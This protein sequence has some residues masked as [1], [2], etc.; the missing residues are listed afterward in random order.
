VRGHA[1][2]IEARAGARPAG[3]R[4]AQRPARILVVAPSW[5][6]DT[7]LAQPLLMR[8]HA[9]HPG[10][11]ID[12]LAPPWTGPLLA[13]MPEV[14]SVIEN[15]FRHG[16][17]KV[18]ARRRLG[19][20]LRQRGYQRAIVLPNTF[21]SALP[22]FFA[23]IPLRTGY[24]GELRAGLLNDVRVLDPKRL[25]LL[26]ERY[27][28]LADAPGK[29]LVRPL[30]RPRLRADPANRERVARTL[31]IDPTRSAVAF[32]PG[33]E[34]G[35]A[36]R[37]PVEHFAALARRA[38][39]AGLQVWLVGSPNDGPI[40]R[41]IAEHAAPASVFDLCGRTTLADAIDLLS[42][43]AAVVSNDSGLMHVAA[44]LD[45]P[46]IALYGSS[47]PAYTPPLSS[48]AAV[49]GLK[50][51]CSPC[52]QRTCPLGHLRCLRDLAPESVWDALAANLG[53]VPTTGRDE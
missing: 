5:V 34:Y 43:A 18:F 35:E 1:A 22:P 29:P 51:D 16:E 40:G 46:L 24:R 42:G 44:A 28:A 14:H 37:W 9:A 21:K 50:L 27:A 4:P 8:L 36:K 30:P 3:A 53:R 32:C 48:S 6:G 15:P 10:L 41:A 47:S 12:V 19:V 11:E 17:L 49:L 52:F 7:V 13:R 23:S 2:G 39:A 33:A 38:I 25:P 45:R 20:E 31:G 26:V